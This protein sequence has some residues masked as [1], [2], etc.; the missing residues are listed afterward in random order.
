M[1]LTLWS[2]EPMEERTLVSDLPRVNYDHYIEAL[3]KHNPWRGEPLLVEESRRWYLYVAWA[4]INGFPLPQKAEHVVYLT[5]LGRDGICLENEK[6]FEV[7]SKEERAK[8]EETLSRAR[9][10]CAHVAA[11][12]GTMCMW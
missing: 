5:F 7:L 8:A 3:D 2:L 12:E 4:I 9:G 1:S 10:H 6:F 11:K